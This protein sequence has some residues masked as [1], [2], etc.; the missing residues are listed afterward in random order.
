[1]QVGRTTERVGYYKR[2]DTFR[3]KSHA[4]RHVSGDAWWVWKFLACNEPCGNQSNP[5]YYKRH[6]WM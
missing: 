3:V 4:Y 5:D 1:M 2:M 6:Y